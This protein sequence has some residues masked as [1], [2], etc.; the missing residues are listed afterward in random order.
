[1]EINN[2]T[3][4]TAAALKVATLRR[5]IPVTKTADFTVAD[6]DS[7]IILNK[8]SAGVVTL[9][10]AASYP[11]RE[12]TLTNIQAFAWTSASANVVPRVGGAAAA[13]MLA[14]TDGAWCTLVS[15]GTNWINLRG[16][17]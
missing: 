6:T 2:G 16:T 12:I 1:M 5:S 13:A 4:G 15:D 10:A 9:P 17:P 14:A 8:G 7:W 11:G 3:A